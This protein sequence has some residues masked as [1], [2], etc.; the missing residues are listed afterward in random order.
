MKKIIYTIIFIILFTPKPAFSLVEHISLDRAVELALENNLDLQSKRK[1]AEELKQDIKI[2]NA[3]KNPQFQSNFLMGKVTRGNSSQFGVAV[4]VE[5]AKRGF[6]K[7]V[8]QIDL[9][10][11]ED[12]IRA[13]EHNLKIKVMEAYFNILYMKSIVAILN[14]RERLFKNM[15]TI[16]E[17]KSK[18]PNYNNIDVLQNDMKYKKQLVFLNQAR[19]NLLGAQFALNDTLNIKGSLIM[20][21]TEESSLFEKDLEI[22]EINL[23]PYQ[24]IEDTAME[25]SYSLSIAESV[26][27][28]SAAEINVAKSKRVPDFTVAGGYAYQTAHQTGGDALP[29]AFVGVNVDFP[30]FY[31]YGPEVKKAKI[32][33]ERSKIDRDS[34]ENHLKFALKQDYN[35]FKYAKENI[36]HYREILKQ[37]KTVLDTYQKLYEKGQATLLKLIQVE[38]AHQETLREY[39]GAVQ[40]Y[41][42]AYLNMMKNVGHDILLPDNNTL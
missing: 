26:I 24:L 20:Y 14:E 10:I 17:E 21:D 13:S 12:E 31:Y 41:Y 38:N 16:V 32:S 35:N 19:A 5:V 7:K 33:L 36:T 22:L 11:T 15:K 18:S 6:R 37:S 42:E 4:P 3:L 2:A 9:K 40:V 1:K 27:D 39:I 28:K 30:L 23:L 34:F 29:G 25:Y 8:A